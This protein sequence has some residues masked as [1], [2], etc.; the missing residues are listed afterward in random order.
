MWP[1]PVSSSL[2]PANL[3][4]CVEQT[5]SHLMNKITTTKWPD[6][7]TLLVSIGLENYVMLFNKQEID[8]VTFASMTDSDLME[9]GVTAFGARRKMMTAIAGK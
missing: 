2:S 4:N 7:T 8:L 9:I 1:M 3:S 5:S 6:I